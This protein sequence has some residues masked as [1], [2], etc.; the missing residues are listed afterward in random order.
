MIYLAS[1]S[2]RRAELLRQIGVDFETLETSIDES[3]LPTESAEEYVCRMAQTKAR[4]GQKMASARARLLPVLAA[5][6]IISIDGS[7]VGKPDD[8]Q[9][10]RRMLARLSARQ[11]QVL[12]AVA[13]SYAGRLELKMSLNQVKFRALEEW[14]IEAY[15]AHKE[16]LDKAGAYAIQGKAAIFIE[17]IEGSY[18]S[19]M[20]LPLFETAALLQETGISVLKQ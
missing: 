20:G 5:D 11:H 13:L 18:S 14:E 3:R 6:T 10:C 15:C 8:A 16:P 19:V 1:S 2:Q 9:D 12:S 7:I 4:A 17:R